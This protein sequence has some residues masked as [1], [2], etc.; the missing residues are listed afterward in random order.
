MKNHIQRFEFGMMHGER[1]IHEY[2][3]RKEAFTNMEKKGAYF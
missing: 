3:Y 2:E 1:S